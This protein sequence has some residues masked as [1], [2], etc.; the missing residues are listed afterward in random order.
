MLLRGEVVVVAGLEL[1]TDQIRECECGSA[2]LA[3]L[4][5]SAL[6]S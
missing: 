2:A 5:T 1:S 6:A 4:S 3:Q